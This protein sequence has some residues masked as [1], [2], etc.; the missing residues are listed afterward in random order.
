MTT[1]EGGIALTNNSKLAARIARIHTHGITRKPTE[2]ENSK[3]QS[4][5]YEQIKLGL[6][7]R[8]SEI[9]AALGL[10]QLNRL[11]YFV[12]RRRQ[13]AMQ[14]DELLTE[15]PLILPN[16]HPEGESTWHLFPVLIDSQQTSLN[17]EQVCHSLLELGIKP[18]VHFIPI[19]TPLFQKNGIQM[20][21]FPRIRVV[22]YE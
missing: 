17:R 11:E 5:E 2:M 6:N 4:W 20:G 10:S 13:L 22:L 8:M 1:S 12:A 14:Y 9:Q 3:P 21:R 18:N 7:Y 19:H 15:L 16:I